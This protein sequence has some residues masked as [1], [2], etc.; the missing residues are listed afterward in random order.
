MTTVS[1]PMATS[2]ALGG[3]DGTQLPE[4]LPVLAD[5]LTGPEHGTWRDVPELPLLALSPFLDASVIREAIAAAFS[6]DAGATAG[7]VDQDPAVAPA[8]QPAPQTADQPNVSVQKVT[9][10]VPLHSAASVGRSAGTPTGGP[11]RSRTPMAA[12]SRKLVPPADF[13]RWIRRE[14]VGSPLTRSDG[15]ATA[16]FLL[17]LIIILLLLYNIITGFLGWISGFLP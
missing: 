16:A 7:A 2:D 12:M 8:P 14:R 6:D 1:E 5:P 10:G 4:P 17:T 13:R 15:G 11:L 3:A 9:G